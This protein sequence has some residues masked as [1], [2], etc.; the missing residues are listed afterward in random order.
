MEEYVAEVTRVS[1]VP[2]RT[3]RYD[4]VSLSPSASATLAEQVSDRVVVGLVGVRAAEAV[5]AVLLIVTVF[6]VAGVPDVVPSFGVTTQY[7]RSPLLK[8]EPVNEVPV[9]LMFRPFT[10]HA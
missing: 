6:D 7:T 5:G 2:L 1:I 10:N 3:Q 4:V 8:A 9:T